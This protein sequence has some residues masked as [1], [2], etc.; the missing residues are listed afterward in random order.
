MTQAG[1][2][3]VLL[4][5]KR[6]AIPTASLLA[7]LNNPEPEVILQALVVLDG[8]RAHN[9]FGMGGRPA[10]LSIREQTL[11][12]AEVGSLTTNRVAL[13]RLFGLNILAHTAD[14]R[15]VDYTLSRLTDPNSLVR[16][17]ASAVLQYLT[18]QEF[19]RDQPDKW[20][21]WWSANKTTYKPRT[22]RD[23]PTALER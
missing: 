7:L 6:E 14:A 15:A 9:F 8:D 11:S 21:Q 1:A 4:G 19:T 23:G 16:I 3:R 2:L 10:G 17:R 5:M 12:S 20:E 22:K 13:V 18:G